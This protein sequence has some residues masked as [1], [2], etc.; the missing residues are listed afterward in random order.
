MANG[1]GTQAEFSRRLGAIESEFGDLKAAV[2][3]LAAGQNAILG[4][5]EQASRDSAD[6]QERLNRP[7]PATNWQGIGALIIAIVGGAFQ[8]LSS[9]T[10]AVRNELNL[11]MSWVKSFMATE[12]AVTKERL[13]ALVSRDFD[14]AEKLYKNGNGKAICPQ[15][16]Y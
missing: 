9:Q 13:E 15:P 11:E 8:L 16:V 7:A 12:Q 6:I 5:L 3:G 2:S 4:R 10:N 1:N 14:L